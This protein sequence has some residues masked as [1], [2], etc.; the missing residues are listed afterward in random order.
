MSVV[1]IPAQLADAAFVFLQKEEGLVLTPYQDTRG[2]WT[3]GIGHLIDA[4]KVGGAAPYSSRWKKGI[5]VDTAKAIFSQDVQM[6][7]N[8][9][10]A[11]AYKDTFRKQ[12]L[13]RQVALLSMA[14]Q[15]GVSG[16][17]RFR[18][19]WRA[20]E[21]GWYDKAADAALDSLWAKQTPA[22][23]QR[24]AQILRTGVL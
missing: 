2:Y 23:A 8:E 22:R 15:M 13:P 5:S 14:F 6:K 20:L 24:T 17:C 19:M 4:R 3:I 12:A 1:E 16:V 21:M 18:T 7:Y 9:L 11:S 10:L